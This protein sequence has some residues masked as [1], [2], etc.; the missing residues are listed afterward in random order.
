[1]ADSLLPERS[2]RLVAALA[3]ILAY[4][5]YALALKLAGARPGVPGSIWHTKRT[6]ELVCV[7]LRVSYCGAALV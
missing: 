2:E 3:G 5:C 7:A 1:M 4:L 6:S